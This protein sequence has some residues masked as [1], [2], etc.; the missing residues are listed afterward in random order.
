MKLLIMLMLLGNAH[1]SELTTIV[2]VDST[3]TS[4]VILI[5][6]IKK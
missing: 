5:N 4:T 3:F 1:A 2:K 6:D